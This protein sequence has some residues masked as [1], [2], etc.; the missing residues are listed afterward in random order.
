MPVQAL[1]WPSRIKTTLNEDLGDELHDFNVLRREGILS[2]KEHDQTR[3]RVMRRYGLPHCNEE[4]SETALNLPRS[5]RLGT[6]IRSNVQN[7]GKASALA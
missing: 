2:D 6:G 4:A 7:L 1:R 3:V 5:R